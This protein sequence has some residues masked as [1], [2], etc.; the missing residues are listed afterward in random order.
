MDDFEQAI[1]D[2]LQ[3][4]ASGSSTAE[5]WLA[6]HPGQSEQLK[7]L[8]QTAGRLGRGRELVPAEAYKKSA[9]SELSAYMQ[10]HS[11]RNRRKPP[12]VWT[13][14]IGLAVLAIAFFVTG[15]ALAQGSLPGQLLYEWKLS[16]EQVWR[17]SSPDRVGVDLELANRRADE[18]TSVA[19]DSTDE[20]KALAGYQEVL[21]RLNTENDKK[22]NDRIRLTLKSNQQ[23]FSAAGIKIPELDTH[24]SP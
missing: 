24:P 1:D 6:Q 19:A 5:E 3:Q 20:A 17:A 18:L 10:A 8:L 16:S 14:A 2:F 11:R 12:L 22:N 4:I 13:I 15:T 9:R 23:K 21:T 7:A